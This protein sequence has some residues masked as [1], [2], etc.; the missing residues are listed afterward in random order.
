MEV[1][2][3]VPSFFVTI[4]LHMATCHFIVVFCDECLLDASNDPSGYP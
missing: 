3:R 2:V 4:T 1:Q